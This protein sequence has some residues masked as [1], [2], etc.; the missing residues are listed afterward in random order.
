MKNEIEKK[1]E[2]WFT[3]VRMTNE[4]MKE[5]KALISFFVEFDV[6]HTE[7]RQRYPSHSVSFREKIDYEIAWLQWLFSI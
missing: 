3:I 7:S 5:L 1:W 2:D 6:Q 4:R